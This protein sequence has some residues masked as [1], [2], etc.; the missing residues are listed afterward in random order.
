[1]VVRDGETVRDGG[2]EE[3]VNPK[4]A[5]LSDPIVG[6]DKITWDD[7]KGPGAITAKPLPSPKSMTDAQRRIHDLTHLPY[8]PG[9]PI[10]VS[11]RRPNDHHR[12]KKDHER[13]IP[14]LCGDY[15][16]P[17]SSSD[18][19]A[20][21]T[22]VMRVYPY[23]IYLCTWVPSK[24]RDPRVVSR[25]VRFMKE[26]GLTH[27]AYRNDRE[28]AIV[29]MIEEACALSGR[30]GVNI[31]PGEDV[32]DE[33]VDV[34]MF[35]SNGE[36]TAADLNVG[37]STGFHDAIPD[38]STHVAT[39]ELSHPGESASNGLAERSVGI[40]MDQLR[41]LKTALESRLKIRLSS[42]HPVTHWLIEHTA[43][44]LNKFSLGPD[45][46]T[47]YGRLHGREGHERICEFGERIMWYVPKKLR[48][49]LDQRWRYGIFLGRSM[50]SDQNFVG[51]SNGD[52]VC[53]RAIVRLTPETR[54]DADRIGS[55]R[56]TPFEF[57]TKN[58]D[59]VE[60]D[61]DPHSHPEPKL[62]DADPRAP[63]RL[64][65][66]DK[67]LTKFG[68]T[69]GCQRCDFV[70]RGQT[71]RAGGVRH[72]EECRKR[73]YEAMRD[74]GL[75]KIKRADDEAPTRTQTR[76]KKH[77]QQRE[78]PPEEVKVLEAPKADHM[79]LIDDQPGDHVQDDHIDDFHM[80]EMPD[81]TNFFEV[82]NAD[83]ELGAGVD[84][85]VEDL[86]DGGEDHVMS[87]MMD[88]LQCLGV[89]AGDSA[90]FCANVLRE[91]P[92]RPTQY[93]PDYNPTFFEVYGQGNIVRASHGVR[94]NLNINGMRAFDL[95]TCKPNG[96]VW[97]FN[98]SADR[99]EARRY[100]EDEK[101][102]WVI[103][104]P[105]CTF[106]SSWNQS[107]N[108]RKMDPVVVEK[109][110]K[111]AV[112]HLRFVIGLYGIQVANG[113]HFLHEH[114]ETATSWSDPAMVALL[115]LPKVSSVVSDQCEYGLL[116]PGPGGIP[117]AAKKPTRWAS[118]S[119]H[120]LKRLSKR[121]SQTHD[122][123]HL[124]GGRAKACE[125]YP[126]ELI[127][128]I[129]RGIRDTADHEEEWGD[130]CVSSLDA[131]VMSAAL[132]HDVRTSSL[133]AAYRAKDLEEETQGLSVRFKHMNGRIEPVN[134]NFKDFY[135]DEYT[136]EQLPM[137][138]VR[139][140]MQEE[141]AYFCDKVWVGVPMA[142]ALEDTDGKII[143]SRWVNCNK[144]DINDPDV[145]CR[146]VAQEINL[147]HDDSFYAATP[148]LEA[149]RMIFSEW[150][151]TQDVYRQLSFIDVKKAYFYGVPDRNLYVRFPPELGM[152]KNMVGKLV[153]CMYGTRDAGSIWE[154]CYTKC[155]VDL[156]FEQGV[157][158]PCCFKHPKWNVSV[159]VHGDD[160]TALG[161]PEG[162]DLYESG[163]CK[164]FECKLKGRLGRGENDL[165]EMRVLNRIVR[166]DDYGLRYE[167]D[168]RHVEL[169][170]RSLN[171]EQCKPVVTPGVKLAFDEEDVDATDGKLEDHV[172]DAPVNALHRR[173]RVVKFKDLVEFH[174]VPTQL[175]TYGA[176]PRTF[177]FDS[178]G[179]M[180][181]RAPRSKE[182][183]YDSVVMEKSPNCRRA[184]LERTLRNG[185]AW[186]TPSIELLAAVSKASK[187]KFMK[188][189]MGNKAAKAHERLECAGDLL[190]D[191]AS[192]MF[193]AVAARYLYLSMDRPE[194]A[195]SS[196][197]LCRQFATPTRKGVEAL[198][199]AVRFLVG[200]PRLV[201]CFDFQ[202]YV[203]T[204]QT[205]V[206]TDF[207]GCHVTRRSTSGGVAMRG[208]HCIKHWSTT[209]STVA[210][211]SGEAELGGICRG[212]SIGLGLQS[213][214]MDLGILL[215]REI[216][217]DAT[218]AIG[219]CRRRGLGKI[220]HLATADLW[221]QDRVRRGDFKL[222]K[223]LGT[224]NPGDLLT[225]HVA[226][227]VML[228]HMERIGIRAESGR[229][230][231]APTIEHK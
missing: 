219:I 126:P 101:P 119:P 199:R 155:L 139:L 46:R 86:A 85:D 208:N 43:Y 28:P 76:S 24:G 173:E 165:K 225:K 50:A 198:K 203:K 206:D 154:G 16:F 170:A 102:T 231:S 13:S 92:M 83:P 185:A 19:E 14:L 31:S 124:V 68:Y 120:M 163:M 84:W 58:Q 64:K 6:M 152:P 156:G 131:T 25:I 62:A 140:A 116:T 122:H 4:H 201:Y 176:P 91:S 2:T 99:R 5:L 59:V 229:A 137:G 134:L 60:E 8:E 63:R 57:K 112:R 38:V 209:Q 37:D 95:R 82:V 36:L 20:L 175:D 103:G 192:T 105:P 223:V 11:C 211:S 1:L 187:K 41:T 53:A 40:F 51:I 90:N 125:N 132:L 189:R 26:V 162:L 55:I 87:P 73:L 108:H 88:V 123:Q 178:H 113:R 177:N 205:Y 72:S 115:S 194:C 188:K 180:I 71:L 17:K 22:L 215:D 100:V 147:H 117:M 174:D 94:R 110:R 23:K 9:C 48:S 145:R 52:V 212:A 27:F 127:T 65:I 230:K 69:E 141:L 66:Y 61:P 136:S 143:G 138:H 135:K 164:A 133:V 157:A 144:N 121:C 45:G 130:E 166:I 89:S 213:L 193:R 56:I 184:I 161:T 54:W 3:D 191:E 210:L 42:S 80:A 226:R 75:E 29:A 204:L 150:A 228:R 114:P 39:P 128:E 200:M 220:R 217:T 153:R 35:I 67:D 172:M 167:A 7:G 216:L 186:E 96:E 129:L 179:R 171:L 195:F 227:D 202:P 146:L 221:V 107:M 12:K 78:E 148:P 109:L 97:D 93:G 77:A 79:E 70:R 30:K 33:D 18:D 98:K 190:D 49:K 196:K 149:K 47:P 159:V 207:G 169:L 181:P 81:S 106:F 168:P 182:E 10:C 151:S 224:D 21:T 104:C 74:A 160:F 118:S 32:L 15:G 218:A 44:V 214:A 183:H 142:E 197:E 111:E 34:N 222:T 158:S